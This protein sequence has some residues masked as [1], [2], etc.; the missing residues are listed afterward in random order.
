[1]NPRTTSRWTVEKSAELYGIRRWGAGFFD[2][3]A[4]GDVTVKVKFP[5]GEVAVSLMEIAQGIAQRDHAMPV[6]LRIENLL[7][8]RIIFLNETFREAIAEKGYEGEYR[9]V[10]P[11]KVNQQSHVIEEITR[12]G[13]RYGHGLEAGSKAELVLAMASLQPGALL[14][15]NGYKDEEFI[16][17]GL[18]AT[19]L[20]YRCFFVIESPAELDIVI[21]RSRAL[22]VR[23]LIG[24]RAKVYAK[25]GGQWTESS[26]DRS[27]FGLSSTQLIEVFEKLNDL[28]MIDCL[29]LLHCHLGSQIPN[30]AD[31]RAGVLEACRYYAALVKEGAPMGYLDFGGGLAVDY[32]GSQSI[33]PHSRNYDL[34]DYCRAIID[35]I[36]ATLDVQGIKHPH[37]VTESGR[38][39]V[40]FSSVLMFNILDVM[41][42]EAVSLPETLPEGSHKRL[43]HLFDLCEDIEDHNL[44]DRY[45]E[46]QAIRG[47]IRDLFRQGHISLRE[48][49]LSENIFLALAQAIAGR[50][51]GLDE[52]PAGLEGL[53]QSLSDIYYGN[54]SVF[55]SLPD[56]WAINQIFPI[57]PLHRNGEAPTRE[58]IIAD[59]T[60]DSDG[61]VDTFI[62]GRGV[63]PTLPLHAVNPDEEY[64]L[65]VFLVGA[66]Q[67]TLGDLHNLL[68][69]TNI[70]SV[71]INEDGSYDVMKEIEGDS[72]ADVLSY[73]EY[74]PQALFENFR[75]IAEVAVREKRIRVEERKQILNEF[76]A[77]LQGYTYFE[78]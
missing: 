21:A 68:G 3:D 59:L 36:R 64:L 32:L 12:F 2:M 66:Y 63:R 13:A 50:I 51:D 27:S 42:F 74:N 56:T 39:T 20:G 46:A 47:Q 23:P 75:A 37:I 19:R 57:V 34:A 72:I 25:V 9:G 24:A 26:G 45:T 8:A 6:L 60:C 28:G 11:V 44:A 71:R 70:V 16:D 65:G 67:E 33:H 29:Q 14:I 76:S 40:A 35:V 61:K 43:R 10:F 4:N 78:K 49:S 48:R 7:D 52:I 22:G 41:H 38:A 69:D 53:R 58:A 77:S 30:L 54:F 1:M 18:R 62:T 5:S 31:I 15:C 73:V 17:L 55:Q